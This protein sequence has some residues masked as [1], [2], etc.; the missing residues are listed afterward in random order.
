VPVSRPGCIACSTPS[1]ERAGERECVRLSPDLCDK[2]ACMLKNHVCLVHFVAFPVWLAPL[3]PVDLSIRKYPIWLPHHLDGLDGRL[4]G[5]DCTFNAA[6][7]VPSE[8]LKTGLNGGFKSSTIFA[9]ICSPVDM[10]RGCRPRGN[11]SAAA[12]AWT[13]A[14]KCIG[15]GRSAQRNVTELAPTQPRFPKI[16]A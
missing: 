15:P 4:C 12:K 5:R 2:A 16:S 9:N 8:P 14:Y 6:N 11:L 7:I 10:T 1:G 13:Q 3:H